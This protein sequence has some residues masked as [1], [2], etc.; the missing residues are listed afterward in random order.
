MKRVLLGLKFIV[1]FIIKP[2]S[3]YFSVVE[4]VCL[5]ELDK[6]P[7]D[8]FVMYFLADHYVQ[9]KKYDEA[10]IL[11]ESLLQ[12]DAD[13][14][15]VI[16]LLSKVYFN[17]QKYKQVKQLFVNFDVLSDKDI[18]NYYLGYSLVELEKRDE[19]IKYLNRYLKHHPKDYNVFAIVGYQY[20][21][22]KM[23]D[24][25]LEAYRQAEKLNP[26]KKEITDSINLCK[27]MIEKTTGNTVH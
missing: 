4:K 16:L 24:L 8:L 25:A 20:Y 21:K 9:Y 18:A 2:S 3:S 7:N 19:G 23:Y 26:S 1:N 17:L 5:K 15:E 11:L 14:K 13:R 6:H 27:E 12:Q 22:E 10:H